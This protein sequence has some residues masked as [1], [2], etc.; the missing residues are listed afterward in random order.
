MINTEESKN[1]RFIHMDF[2]SILQ[3]ME[4]LNKY[5]AELIELNIND[6][7]QAIQ[8]IRSAIAS[9]MDWNQVN[10]GCRFTFFSWLKL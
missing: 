5:R 3:D 10:L 6:V 4:E 9:S 1:Y 7:E 2:N 8:I